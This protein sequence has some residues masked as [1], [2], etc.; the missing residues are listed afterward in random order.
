MFERKFLTVL[1]EEEGLACDIFKLLDELALHELSALAVKYL[2]EFEAFFTQL[3]KDLALHQHADFQ[4]KTK[5]NEM[6][7]EWDFSEACE[8]K[9][10]DFEAKK[11][12]RL[13]HQ[14]AFDQKI[15][16]YQAQIAKLNKKITEVEA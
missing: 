10:S 13:N 4:I 1:E 3:V 8:K 16:D 5:I 9:L 15:S 14:Q 12:D 6:R 2:I 7:L 11:Q